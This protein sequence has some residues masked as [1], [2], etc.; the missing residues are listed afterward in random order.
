MKIKIVAAGNFPE[1]RRLKEEFDVGADGDICV[2]I[3][4]D[5]TFVRAAREYDGPI[6]PIRG[7]AP[8][9]SG[10]Y[11]DASLERMEE[12]IDK[13]TGRKFHIEALEKK[14]EIVYNGKRHYAVNE[15]V[16]RNMQREVN[17]KVYEKR[18][19]NLEEIYPFVMGGDGVLVTGA[20]GS[21]AYNKSAGGPII[22]SPA[23]FCLTFLNAD[24]PYRNPIV[25]G[26]M[27]RIVVKVV[28]YRGALE[29]D[30][31]RISTL[32]PGRSFEVRLSD[33]DLSIVRLQ[34]MQEGMA[35]KLE[36]IISS[37]M[38]RDL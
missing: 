15:A 13:L 28:K 11:A 18:D 21:T 33:R 20:I 16:L 24:G 38:V 35:S 31:M 17:F 10:Y 8:G 26:A 36:R 30:G 25:V 4:G 1:I 32:A 6:L 29:Y 5:G 2:A 19:G 37:R 9:S 7:G 14:L 12:I 3:G 34:G 27:K 22:L 23:V